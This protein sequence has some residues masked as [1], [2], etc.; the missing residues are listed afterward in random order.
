MTHDYTYSSHGV[1][2]PPPD[3]ERKWTLAQTVV[4]YL[5]MVALCIGVLVAFLGYVRVRE[6][7]AARQA[8]LDVA[9]KY[10]RAF[11][12][13]RDVMQLADSL[14]RGGAPWTE[15]Q[16]VLAEAWRDMGRGGIV[17]RPAR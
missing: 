7:E 12:A 3:G 10:A 16:A 11:A 13:C 5:A 15:E 1:H 8:R 4:I 9:S 14:E 2:V 17:V 6:Q